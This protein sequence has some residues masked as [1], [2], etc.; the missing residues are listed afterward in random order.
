MSSSEIPPFPLSARGPG[1]RAHSG[2]MARPAGPDHLQRA[3]GL[4]AGAVLLAACAAT[5]AGRCAAAEP[6]GM[7]ETVH[8]HR[9]LTTT[10]TDDGDLNPYAV[11]VAPATV[12]R[13]Q[14]GDVLVDNFN[15]LSNLQGTGGTIVDYNPASKKTTLFA[16]IPQHLPQCPGGVGLTAAMAML[17]SGFVIVGSAPSTDGTTRTR[18]DGGLIVLDAT[19][20]V[21]TVWSGPVSAIPGA[22]SRSSIMAIPPRSSS[23]WPASM[24]PD[25]RSAIR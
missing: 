13:I 6:A 24:S 17:S 7:L 8:H 15:N 1:G 25:R 19:G 21:V 20:A 22:T 18:G 10:V 14:K 23:A 12:G 16:K 4:C 5:M 2:G 3:C 9:T 11:V